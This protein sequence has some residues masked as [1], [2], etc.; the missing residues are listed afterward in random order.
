MRWEVG[1]ITCPREKSTL[2]QT[3]ESLYG[4]GWYVTQIFNDPDFSGCYHNWRKCARRLLDRSDGGLIF[5]AEDDILI[6]R[7]LRRY[8][9]RTQLPDGVISLYTA[10]PNHGEHGWNQ[11]TNLPKR[12]N[13]ALATV[14]R[15]ELLERFLEYDRSEEFKNGTDTLIGMW[16]KQNAPLW[17]HSPSFVKHIGET[18]TIDPVWD[19]VQQYQRQ[20][21]EWLPEFLNG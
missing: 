10:A 16:C 18:S 1:V 7:G 5:I 17:C 13:G 6:T 3:L 15:P 9:E 14:W 11:I 2:T 20:C 8:L 12:S 19:E 21:K 4:A